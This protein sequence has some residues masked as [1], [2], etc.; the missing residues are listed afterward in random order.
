EPWTT[1]IAALLGF[2]ADRGK[3]Y[4]PGVRPAATGGGG[5]LEAQLEVSGFEP[6]TLDDPALG[7]Q[8][9]QEGRI[10]RLGD[11]QAISPDA[12]ERRKALLVEECERAGTISLATFRDRAGVSRR[13]AQLVLER[14]DADRL[15]LRVGDERRLRRAARR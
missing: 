9:E 6:V 14:F 3:L 11:P 8:L 5:A 4:L 7:R 15:T 2:E 13:V 12:Y 10:V 1:A